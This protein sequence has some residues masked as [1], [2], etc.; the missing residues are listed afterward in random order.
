MN[1]YLIGFYNPKAL[2]L[3]YLERALQ[4]AGHEVRIL[5]FKSF[6]SMNP[7]AAD[8]REL[9]LLRQDIQAFKPG[10]IGLSVMAS[11]YLETVDAVS[12]ML[13]EA[14]T[15]P[16]VWGGVYPTMFPEE[17]LKRC[18][19]VLRGEGEEAVVELVSALASGGAVNGIANLAYRQG[20]ETVIN[21]LRP[22]ERDLDRF[23]LPDIGGDN[24]ALIENSA[25]TPG[26]PQLSSYSYETGAG[27]GCPYACSYCCSV[28][29]NR[30]HRGLGPV[31]RFR[32]PDMVIEELL[33][34]K[35]RMKK[36]LFIHFWD[37]IFSDDPEWVRRFAARY[38][39]EI[40]LPF[41]IWGHPLKTNR[42]TVMTLRK[43]GLYKV[44]MGI[45]SGSPA[46]RK[47]VFHRPESQ[48]D[49]LAAARTLKEC[50]VP[51]IIYD[52]M[53]RHPFET[54]ETI[55][56]TFAFCLS[57]PRGFSLQ[58]HGLNFLPGTDIV[59]MAVERGLVPP[60]EMASLTS[61]GMEDQYSR[62]W[63]RD[64]QNPV[65][66][67]WYHLIYLTQFGLYRRKTVRLS[68]DP[69]SAENRRKAERAVRRAASLEKMR[70]LI[71]KLR[72]AWR[73]FWR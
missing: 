25:L 57:M 51:H 28:N 22:L 46:I 47:D 11:L 35:R 38:K 32:D 8:E 72:T 54:E 41:E 33:L 68:R 65:I 67:F 2:G 70:N 24:K 63:K 27:R 59:G 66:N 45:Q 34:A 61:A 14:F 64:N 6:N 23:G 52:L 26:D 13:R 15:V 17:C 29:L 69:L 16:I 36:L 60:D 9:A 58:M 19:Y 56:E 50:G 53:L 4:S 37:E 48:E 20:E 73:G 7:K 1:V 31:V 18:D 55:R 42:D 49:I 10:M 21:P 39:K 44:V 30:L 5:F 12:A 43:A 62:H 40:K 71:H 3:R